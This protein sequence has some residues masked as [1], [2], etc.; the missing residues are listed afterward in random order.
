MTKP[1]ES[2][3][4]SSPTVARRPLASIDAGHGRQA[5]S[6]KG[7]AIPPLAWLAITTHWA[8]SRSVD[9]TPPPRHAPDA[10]TTRRDVSRDQWTRVV[11]AHDRSHRRDVITA[12]DDSP[13]PYIIGVHAFGR[14]Q[15]G[16][17]RLDAHRRSLD[18]GPKRLESGR[19]K[20]YAGKG[21]GDDRT[22]LAPLE[23]DEAHLVF[24]HQVVTHVQLP[25]TL[26]GFLVV[27]TTHHRRAV[28]VS[29]EVD[30][31]ALT[32]DRDDHARVHMACL[33]RAAQQLTGW[34]DSQAR[35]QA[36]LACHCHASVTTVTRAKLEARQPHGDA[37]SSCF[38]VSL[39]R[40]A[41]HQQLLSMIAMTSSPF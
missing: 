14:P 22:R 39:T 30:V 28:L 35:S 34:C 29:P 36:T 3:P 2:T 7:L 25:C 37:G 31:D 15:M 27:D 11:S 21:H 16:T 13:Q 24:S 4:G 40:R 5:R 38:M 33:F 17:R 32:I 10:E 26:R 12:G 20:T 6:A 9:Q 23:T 8:D 19:P 1:W 41:R 18:P